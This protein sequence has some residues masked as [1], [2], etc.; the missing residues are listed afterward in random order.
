MPTWCD[1][2]NVINDPSLAFNISEGCFSNR[3]PW[4]QRDYFPAALILAKNLNRPKPSILPR[5]CSTILYYSESQAYRSIGQHSLSRNFKP[6]Q[7]SLRLLREQTPRL[8]ITCVIVTLIIVTLRAF[9]NDSNVSRDYKHIFNAITTILGLALGLNFLEAFKDMAKVLRWRILAKSSYTIREVDLIL[10][11]ESLMKLVKLMGASIRKPLVVFACAIWIFLN[12]AA[13]GSIAM[14]GLTYSMD[15]GYASNGTYTKRGEVHMAK[16]DCYY[17][18]KGVCRKA[19]ESGMAVAHSLGQLIQGRNSC[20]YVTENDISVASQLCFYFNR[21]DNQEF[22]YRFNEYNPEDS[23]ESYPYLTERNIRASTGLCSEYAVNW[24]KMVMIDTTDGREEAFFLPIYNQ[25]YNGTITIPRP[26]TG[27]D[28]TTYIYN[29]TKM[30]QDEL[31]QS[32]GPRC[33]WMYAFRSHGVITKRKDAVFACPITVSEV[34]NA[35]A[36]Y[37]NL[38][39]DMA[40]LAAASIGL[41]GRYT[42]PNKKGEKNRVWTQ[43]QFYSWGSDWEIEGLDAQGVGAR[44]ALFALGSI[45]GMASLNPRLQQSG[46]LPILGYHLEIHWN[47]VIALAAVITGLHAVF[48]ALMVW[49][50]RPIVV[51]DDSNLCTAR[52]LQGLVGR[53]DGSGCLLDG[54]EVANAIQEKI[55]ENR[56]VSGAA[57]VTYGVDHTEIGALNTI[58]LGE[59]MA[60]RKDLPRRRFPKG[61]YA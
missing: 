39:D 13:Q 22:A 21:E 2:I 27:F 46:T 59:S 1:S 47:Y 17:D 44:M 4:L 51:V 45:A 18:N 41:E 31:T 48:V 12:L 35:N 49:I 9:E 37:H 56:E 28:A 33:L 10:G 60:M 16:L 42:N 30:P 43:Y 32:C 36:S 29:G 6:N 23:T 5:V 26:A 11:G 38:P 19:D 15:A 34:H 55:L 52:L 14:I 61:L 58:G 57:G 53:L 8:L 54:R 7:Q 20:S 40:L 3:L 25:T 24:D 50:A